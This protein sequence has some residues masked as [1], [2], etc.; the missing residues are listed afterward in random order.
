MK[1]NKECQI[2]VRVTANQKERIDKY[3]EVNGLNLSQ[4]L[5]LAIN[6]IL[7]GYK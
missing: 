7:G 1:E 6:E 5:R 4:F 3:C 2:K